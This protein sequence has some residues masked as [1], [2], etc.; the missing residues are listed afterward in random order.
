[1]VKTFVNSFKF[2][3]TQNANISI[4][5]LKRIPLLGKKIPERLYKQTRSKV[6]LGIISEILG[7]LCIFFKKFLYLLVLIILPSLFIAGNASPILP[8]FLHIFFFWGPLWNQYLILI[9]CQPFI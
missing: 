4:Y 6:I 2:S 9:I 5:F 8:E 3:F 7:L 1:M